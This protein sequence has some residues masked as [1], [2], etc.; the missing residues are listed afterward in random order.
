[1]MDINNQHQNYNPLDDS[2]KQVTLCNG[3]TVSLSKYRRE[4]EESSNNNQLQQDQPCSS[5]QSSSQENNGQ[6]RIIQLEI[7]FP[8]GDQRSLTCIV[9]AGPTCE[10]I[11]EILQ[12]IDVPIA[13]RNA[14][15][16]ETG[17]NSYLVKFVQQ[18]LTLGIPQ[19][20][21][22]WPRNFK[23]A[24]G[25]AVCPNCGVCNVADLQRCV[26]YDLNEKLLFTI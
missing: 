14:K 8:N 13:G 26:R 17:P 16:K 20:V 3:K 23:K 7:A 15:Y 1:M 10:I 6:P 9:R 12:E 19:A 22:T 4:I 25:F 11:S 21:A 2:D 5:G 18:E 24:P